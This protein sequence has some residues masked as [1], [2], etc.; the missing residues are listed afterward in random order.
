M[1]L[2]VFAE[3][4]A[5]VHLLKKDSRIRGRQRQDKLKAAGQA[6]TFYCGH[7]KLVVLDEALGMRYKTSREIGLWLPNQWLETVLT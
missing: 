4:G 3:S 5:V 6:L 7:L 1:T 2:R